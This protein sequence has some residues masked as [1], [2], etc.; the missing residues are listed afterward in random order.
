MGR[1]AYPHMPV[2]LM[3][4]VTWPSLRLSP[5]LML[6]RLGCDSPTQRSWAGLVYTPTLDLV[7]VVVVDI[8]RDFVV[9]LKDD[10]EVE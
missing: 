1:M 7:T 10:Q 8:V 6:S 5:P 2:L 4:I 3:P 9:G